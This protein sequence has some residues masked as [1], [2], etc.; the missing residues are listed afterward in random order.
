MNTITI[1]DVI[2]RGNRIDYIYQIDGA[3]Q[4]YFCR[5]QPF[6]VEYSQNYFSKNNSKSAMRI[7]AWR[8]E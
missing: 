6:F 8:F 7:C 1:S 4:S 5:E 2:Q 3:W